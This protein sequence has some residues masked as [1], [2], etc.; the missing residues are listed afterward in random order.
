MNCE[1]CKDTGWVTPERMKPTDKVLHQMCTCVK[2]V[3]PDETLE[4][5]QADIADLTKEATAY[6]EEVRVVAEEIEQRVYDI[7]TRLEQLLLRTE[8][9]Q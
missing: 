9:N 3:R 5:I 4:D 8:A 1:L 2:V 7:Q 6:M